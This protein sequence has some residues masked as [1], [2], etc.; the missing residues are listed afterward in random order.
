[1]P[2][3]MHA[4]SLERAA[5]L[6]LH[7]AE[8]VAV[9]RA[10]H[11][12]WSHAWLDIVGKGRAALPAGW[13]DG[14]ARIETSKYAGPIKLPAKPA[15]L[16]TARCR[17]AFAGSAR[18][19]VW[20]RSSRIAH[21][22]DAAG[23]E[24]CVHWEHGTAWF[25]G[26]ERERLRYFERVPL[27]LANSK[28]AA[29]VLES[30][31]RYRGEI[32]VCPNGLRPSL[33]PDGVR[34]KPYPR[35]RPVR[36][37]VAAR[38]EPVKGVALAVHALGALRARGIDAELHVAGAG[39]GRE[40]LEALAARLGVDAHVRCLG[41]VGDMAAFYDDVDCLI[42][43]PL[44]EAFGLVALE[45]A[46]RGCPVVAAGVDGLAG[47]VADGLGGSVVA[48]TLPVSDYPALGGDL[49]GL[50]AHVYDPATDALISPLLADPDALAAAVER[51]LGDADL[52]ER[53]SATASRHVLERFAFERHVD[54]VMAVLTGER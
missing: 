8:F 6:E 42:H 10:R 11:P 7:C 14:F 53:T 26:R 20:N 25:G 30:L 33:R 27:A 37:G 36:I 22:V 46:A 12:G 44:S 47:V 9:A 2:S 15:W 5:G 19:V 1:M 38:L 16:R 48:P 41:F 18:M 28:A 51:L 35:T 34:S 52:Y 43:A 4:V 21:V 50:P 31:W 39:P 29:R 49:D 32:R 17:R 3:L 24:R 54:D 45:A 13:D 23:A 40:R